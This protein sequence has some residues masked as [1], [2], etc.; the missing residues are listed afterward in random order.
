MMGTGMLMLFVALF[1]PIRIWCSWKNA[2]DE[3]KEQDARDIEAQW[4]VDII[5]RRLDKMCDEDV[6]K[7]GRLTEVNGIYRVHKHTDIRV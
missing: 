5:Q 4:G 1:I 2:A 6:L 3:R 7:G